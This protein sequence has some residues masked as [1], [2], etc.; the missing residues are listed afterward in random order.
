MKISLFF[1][2]CALLSTG[3]NL[4]AQNSRRAIDLKLTTLFKHMAATENHMR[5]DSL[6][7]QFE[8]SLLQELQSPATLTGNLDSLSTYM[9]IHSLP[10]TN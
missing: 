5:C 1:L 7:P 4:S 9:T 3:I 10:I 8:T 2:V 6:E